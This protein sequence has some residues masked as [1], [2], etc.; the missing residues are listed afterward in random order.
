M[1]IQGGAQWQRVVART[2]SAAGRDLWESAS[3]RTDARIC[4][5][6][7]HQSGLII[8]AMWVST[9]YNPGWLAR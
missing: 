4:P 7:R 8:A 6:C 3:Y 2:I 1:T 9:V 5:P